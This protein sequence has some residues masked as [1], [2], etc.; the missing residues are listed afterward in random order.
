MSGYSR[1]DCREIVVCGLVGFLRKRQKRLEENEGKV[2]RK[3]K[4]TIKSRNKKKLMANTNWFK[5]KKTEEEKDENLKAT[6]PQE[7]KA[8]Y[9][10]R[11]KVKKIVK[12][13]MKGV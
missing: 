10:E 2:Y 1:R 4:D 11:R 12:K 5:N 7:Q 6:M 3:G 13:E 9:V 8:K